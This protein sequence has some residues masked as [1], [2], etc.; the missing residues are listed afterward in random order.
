[1]CHNWEF[2]SEV[3]LSLVRRRKLDIQPCSVLK[4]EQIESQLAQLWDGSN[5]PLLIG[6]I[7]NHRWISEGLLI[8]ETCQ[9]KVPGT[10]SNC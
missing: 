6:A 4:V 9:E 8:L 3:Q 5:M 1:M 10:R 2:Y 7:L